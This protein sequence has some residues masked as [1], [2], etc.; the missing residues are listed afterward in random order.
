M[1]GMTVHTWTLG[2]VQG[3]LVPQG[4][5]QAADAVL[6]NHAGLNPRPA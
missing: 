1:A 3:Q 6:G 4:H 2:P 5:A